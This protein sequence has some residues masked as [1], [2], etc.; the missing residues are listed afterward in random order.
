MR[1]EVYALDS[2]GDV[3]A[4][5]LAPL[6]YDVASAITVTDPATGNLLLFHGSTPDTFYEH[7]YSTDSWV[8]HDHPPEFSLINAYDDLSAVA[9][10]IPEYGVI[11]F[12]L[13][14][15]DESAVYLYKHAP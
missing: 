1:R 12:F 14:N 11:I 4:L 2:A 13:D 6:E 7:V 5:A 8:S 9:T 15:W 10:G 3:S